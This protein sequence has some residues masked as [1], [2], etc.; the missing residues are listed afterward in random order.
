MSTV[1]LASNR[2]HSKLVWEPFGD[3]TTVQTRPSLSLSGKKVHL[4]RW[5][6]ET[7]LLEEHKISRAEHQSLHSARKV[8]EQ[9]LYV[10]KIPFVHFPPF[11]SR[12]TTTWEV[13]EWISI[14]DW[15]CLCIGLK[16]LFVAS[17]DELQLITKLSLQYTK[18][19]LAPWSGWHDTTGYLWSTAA[20]LLSS[21]KVVIPDKAGET[22]ENETAVSILC[23]GICLP[24]LTSITNYG[25]VLSLSGRLH[26]SQQVPNQPFKGWYWIWPYIHCTMKTG[27]RGP[28]VRTPCA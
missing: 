15:C 11:P 22:V 7:N 16:K 13:K 4:K 9:T 21:K 1:S 26:L 18:S 24:T 12:D 3:V 17:N 25:T 5:V 27:S 20:M 14:Q 2:R 6:P 10:N 8:M 19:L 28:G 23:D